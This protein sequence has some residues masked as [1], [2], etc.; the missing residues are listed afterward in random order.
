MVAIY[1]LIG[2]ISGILGGM[3]MGGG[4]LLIPLLTLVLDFNQRLA[5]GINL[6]SFC[7]MA[8]FALV[9]HIKNGYVDF[10][11]A[12]KFGIFATIFAILG[13]FLANLISFIIL[14]KLFGCLLIAISFYLIVHQ[15]REWYGADDGK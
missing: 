8:I 11:I 1:L 7:I 9:I 5:Q 12:L 3:G 4:T 14:R 15:L 2:V 10:K 6:I 13:A